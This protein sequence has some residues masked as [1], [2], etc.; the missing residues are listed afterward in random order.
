MLP[1]A[2]GAI[3]AAVFI[4]DSGKHESYRAAFEL[5]ATELG[6]TAFGGQ[7]Y[8]DVIMTDD[9]WA[10][11]DALRDVWDQSVLLLCLFHVTQSVW[12]WLLDAKHGI[13]KEDREWLM[14]DFLLL[15]RAKTT[16]EA[17]RLYAECRRS[18]QIY[19]NY[20]INW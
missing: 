3:P 6:Q 11:R 18:G 1:T 9:C 19:P 15:I 20:L 7:G 4:T 2:A 17:Y 5:L 16:V 10:E 8:P 12:R 14:R 13:D